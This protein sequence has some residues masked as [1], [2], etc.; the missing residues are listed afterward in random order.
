MFCQKCGSLINEGDSFCPNCGAKCD[1]G[2]LS[3]PADTAQSPKKKKEK[4][5][6]SKAKKILIAVL[7]ILI[8]L[9]ATAAGLGITYL[10]SNEYKVSRAMSKGNYNEAL[11]IYK[12]EIEGKPSRLIDRTIKN[13]LSTLKEN[14][15]NGSVDYNT[16]RQELDAIEEMGLSSIS[17]D[18]KSVNDYIVSLE[19]SRTSFAQ[20]ESAF[21]KGDFENAVTQYKNVIEA[22]SNYETAQQKLIEAIEKFRENSLSEAASFVNE[23]LYTK[24]IATLESA[25]DI[26]ADDEK[27]SAQLTVY[28]ES[29]Q[30]QVKTEALKSAEEYAIKKDYLNALKTIRTALETNPDDA[31]LSGKAEV[32]AKDYEEDILKKADELLKNYQFDEAEVLLTEAKKELPDSIKISEKSDSVDK[33]RPTNLDSLFVIDSYQYEY[34]PEV[35]TDSFGFDHD[36][37]HSFN[38]GNF[39]TAYAVYNLN[40]QHTSVQFSI[41]AFTGTRSNTRFDVSIFVDDKLIQTIKGITKTSGKKD[42][43]IDVTDAT[44]LEIRVT[45]D[46]NLWTAD[47]MAIALVNTGNSIKSSSAGVD[48]DTLELKDLF[49]I[50]SSAYEYHDEVFTDSSGKDHDGYHSLNCGNFTTGY[51]VFNLNN[52]YNTV[53][54]SL[55]ALSDTRENTRFTVTVLLDGKQAQTVPDFT[56]AA[57]NKTVKIDVKGATKM[58]IQLTSEDN[59]WTTNGMSVGMV[60]AYVS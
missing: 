49:V 27:I 52:Q 53:E 59:D 33:L 13:H 32:Y 55:A 25:L 21:S 7:S 2:D 42:V 28:Q 45:S 3:Q 41:V 58:E 18:Y 23:G 11:S 19:K 24:A 16:A 6:M 54:F 5:K 12:N 51:A 15:E 26:L 48:G 9:A 60:D 17:Q 31:V 34:N 20:A 1:Y 10:T 57:G 37:Y 56:T 22:D 14:F 50:D 29:Y 40:K 44:K 4:K 35:L 46:D 38:C 8:V 43:R 36:G 39:T 47:G 30:A